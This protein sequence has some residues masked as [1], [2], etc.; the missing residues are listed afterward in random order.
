MWRA[1]HYRKYVALLWQTQPA[2][3]LCQKR[4]GSLQALQKICEDGAG[5]GP[6]RMIPQKTRV[7][8]QVRVRFAGCYP[9]KS[10]LVCCVALPRKLASLRFEKITEYTRE[11][12]GH[13]F[14]VSSENDLDAEVQG[15]LR[16]AYRVGAQ[17]KLIV[18][19]PSSTAS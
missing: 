9:R 6:V 18:D 12:I 2:S 3:P 17:E 10:F 1:V 4:A 14:R 7:V 13:Q 16:D 8:F 15:W 5:C 19:G 11:F